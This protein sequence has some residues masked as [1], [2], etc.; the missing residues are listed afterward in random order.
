MLI[1]ISVS[2]L[3]RYVLLVGLDVTCLRFEI[4]KEKE[5][6]IN[7]YNTTMYIIAKNTFQG[8]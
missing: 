3:V 7:D 4:S 8:K 6:S 2:Q 5:H 1:Q